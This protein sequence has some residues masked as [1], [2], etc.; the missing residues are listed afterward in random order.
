MKAKKVVA[1]FMTA[2]MTMGMLAGCGS[3]NSNTGTANAG[4]TNAESKT[5]ASESADAAGTESTGNIDTADLAGTQITM[6]NS[7]GEIQTALEDMAE[8]FKEDTGIELEVQACGT[9]E[10]PYTRVTSAYNSGTAPT[11][12]ILDTTDVVALASQY[13]VDLSDEEWV[14]ECVNQ[15][16][17]VD[18]KIYSFPFCVEGRGIIY[19]KSAIEDTLGEEFDPST[20]NSY[21]ALKEL[22][23]NLRAC[24][25]ENPVV[26]SK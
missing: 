17:Q 6:L 15:T 5:D 21:D 1:V 25:I 20:I 23:E 3:N 19:N 26:I 14:K 24:G 10:S 22:L 11:M 7:K 16:T 12:A 9:G 8:A 2:A 4:S 18:G 13:A